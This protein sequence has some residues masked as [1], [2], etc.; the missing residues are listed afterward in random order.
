MIYKT[1]LII[2]VAFV[3]VVILI[4]LILSAVGID[5]IAGRGGGAAGP[6]AA[7]LMRSRDR[8]EHWDTPTFIR[9]RRDPSPAYVYN[10]APH[11]VATTTLLAGTKGAG[12][13]KSEDAGVTWWQVKDSSGALD[14]RSDVY[15]V[16]MN[17]S[18]PG[19]VYLAAYQDGRGRVFRS[20][21]GAVSFHQIY[22]TGQQ[23]YGIFDLATPPA[24]PD[25]VL[26]ATGEGRLLLSKDGGRQWRFAKVFRD[27]L[28][29]LV[30]HPWYAS[31]GY[32]LTSKG[33][34][35]KTYDGGSV[36]QDLGLLNRSLRTTTANRRV[37]EHPFTRLSFTPGRTTTGRQTLRDMLVP[38]P[39]HA[40]LV[41]RTVQGALFRSTDGGAGWEP[42]ST[43]IDGLNVPVGGVAVH[44]AE[45]DTL[46][47]TAGQ[48]LYTSRDR[49][50]NWS[51][52]PF[53]N[54]LPLREVYIHPGAPE[55]MFIAAGR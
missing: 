2:V 28:L 50:V 4:P 14:I 39:H 17:R 26:V 36:W 22:F 33:Q 34:I 49:G 46:M 15:R 20:D 55:I 41:Y 18:R 6:D 19:V 45:P 30:M 8:G 21:D 48:A 16:A 44:P 54:R 35:F 9:E 38:D 31:E 12:L 10:I 25:T 7:I 43:F 40:G 52:V 11:P 37:I 5:L 24:E 23:G 13:W 53:T 51:I 29:R 1:I 27:P 32:A 3:A 42:L 47:V